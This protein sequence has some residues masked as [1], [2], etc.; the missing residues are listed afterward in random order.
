M[1]V[2]FISICTAIGAVTAYYAQPYTH[3]NADLIL[4]VATVFTV[5][6]GFLIAIITIIGD[7]IM[8]PDGSWRIA[9]GGRERMDQRLG[10]HVALFILYLLTIGF[11]FAG[12]ILDKALSEDSLWKIWVDRFYLFFGVTSF[13]FTFALPSALLEMQ[14]LRYDAETERRRKAAGIADNGGARDH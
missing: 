7:P 4:I 14:R 8:I 10:W 11:L 6:A 3:H 1:R 9:E 2:V 13:L 5:F 12:V